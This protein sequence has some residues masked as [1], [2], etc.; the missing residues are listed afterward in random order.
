MRAALVTGGSSGIGFAIARV[1][2]RAGHA[3][4][5]TSR[6]QDRLDEA[7]E[8]LRVEGCTVE[9]IPANL[10]DEAALAAVVAGHEAA[11][12][13]LDVL[14][15][16]AGMGIP[17]EIDEYSVKHIDLQ[18]AV[19]LRAVVLG[20]HYGVPLLRRAG[21][22]HRNALVV[23]TASVTAERPQ[24]LMPLYATTKAAVVGLTRAMNRDLG[25]AGIKSCALCPGI[26]ATE[27]T[28]DE[29]MPDAE[30]IA[31][32]DVAGAVAWLLTTSPSCVVPEIPFLR[33]GGID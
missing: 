30:K 8:T 33:P 28:A 31:P 12:G 7:A 6:R 16:N 32:E 1:L 19:N 11:Y 24:P 10:A 4:T 5:I 9:A 22:E 23:N 25:A 21:A 20:Y 2:G 3:L 27:M 14:V 26:V 18:L 13:R 29:A 17:G 15:N